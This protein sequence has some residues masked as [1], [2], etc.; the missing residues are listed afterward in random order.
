MVMVLTFHTED[1]DGVGDALNILLF[2]DLFPLEG[3]E[4]A[5]LTRKW[6]AILGGGTL[7]FFEETSFLM[8]KQKVAPSQDGTRQCPNSRLGPYFNKC[9]WDMT[10]STPPRTRCSYSWRRHLESSRG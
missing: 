7:T 1:P 4:A 6:D 10:G 2:P 5:L 8:V 9:S 3:S